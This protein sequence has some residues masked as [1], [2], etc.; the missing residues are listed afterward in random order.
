MPIPW[1]PT[2]NCLVRCLSPRKAYEQLPIPSPWNGGNFYHADAK[3]SRAHLRETPLRLNQNGIEE[4]ADY[5]AGSGSAL[6]ELKACTPA[7]L[8]PSNG[9]TGLFWPRQKSSSL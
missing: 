2:S 4:N 7:S 8:S 6:A 3:R 5:G 1:S 9:V